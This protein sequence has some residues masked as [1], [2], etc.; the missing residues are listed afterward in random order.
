MEG[1][2][3]GCDSWFNNPLSEVSAHYGVGKDG[4]IH[5]YVKESEG[6]WATGD[7]HWNCRSLNIEHEGFSGEPWPEAMIESTAWLLRKFWRDWGIEPTDKTVLRHSAI[8]PSKPG[9]PGPGCPL[10]RI[11]AEARRL[12][13]L[14]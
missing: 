2:L 6:A 5:Q 13:P 10:D 12:G 4:E 8:N 14:P 7:W 1:T 11:V 3:E 9:C